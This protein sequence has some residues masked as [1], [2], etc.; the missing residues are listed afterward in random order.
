MYNYLFEI[1][2]MYLFAKTD[3]TSNENVDVVGCRR[4]SNL[5]LL[6]NCF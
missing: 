1:I 4:I 3:I 5:V 2:F 6:Q